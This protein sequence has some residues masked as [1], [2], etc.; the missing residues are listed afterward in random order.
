ME[1]ASIISPPLHLPEKATK[2]PSTLT[3]VTLY[4]PSPGRRK[5][6]LLV[7]EPGP[8]HS[9]NALV[10]VTWPIVYFGGTSFPAAASISCNELFHQPATRASESCRLRK[11]GGRDLQCLLY[12]L[13]TPGYMVR[14]TADHPAWK[15]Q[16]LELSSSA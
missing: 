11:Q 9:H 15:A 13:S 6:L 3:A 16:L 5:K 2:P 1:Y 7:L 8:A 14:P 10:T 4:A 12:I